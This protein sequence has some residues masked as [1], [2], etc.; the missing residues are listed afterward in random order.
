VIKVVDENVLIVANDLTR[1]SAGLEPECPEADDACGLRCAD[2]LVELTESGQVGL[3]EG[4]EVFDKYRS[5]CNFSG[6][7]GI[8]DAFLRAVFERGYD[9]TWA[10]RVEVRNEHGLIIPEQLEQSG[11]DNDDY[12][13]VAVSLN[14][15]E[16]S[17]IL[18]AV[19]S[20]YNIW[21]DLLKDL[22]VNVTEL[23]C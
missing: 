18:N 17:T 21:R 5:H 13:W 4:T 3:D 14:C 9:P 10:K 23:C 2:A 1:R 22:G 15:G 19:D 12:I 6:Q 8:G 16:P 11:F 7:P 20:D